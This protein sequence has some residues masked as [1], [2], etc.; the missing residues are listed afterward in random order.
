MRAL[1]LVWQHTYLVTDH[2]Q[3]Y[4]TEAGPVSSTAEWN[5][6]E[7]KRTRMRRELFPDIFEY[8]CLLR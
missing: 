5:A 3:T 7:E 8:A 1:T 6:A 4:G 2:K